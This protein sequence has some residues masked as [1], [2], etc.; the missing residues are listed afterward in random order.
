MTQGGIHFEISVDGEVQ[1]SRAL[2][3]F[4]DRLFH[5]RPFFATAAEQVQKSVAAQFDAQGG[6]TGGWRPLSPRY[7]AYKLAQVGSKPILEYSGRMRRSLTGQGGDSIRE[8]DDNHLRWGTRTP[9]AIYHQRGTRRMPQRR[10]IDLTEDDRRG[11]MKSLQQFLMQAW[12]GQ[13]L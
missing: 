7:A 8:L 4:G 5:M 10:I 11:L 3:R 6:R 1:L 13:G 12:E 9:Y 2:S